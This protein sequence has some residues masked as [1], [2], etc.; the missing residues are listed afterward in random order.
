[1]I[2]KEKFICDMY[3]FL[4]SKGEHEL[5]EEFHEVFVAKCDREEYIELYQTR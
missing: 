5:I 1:M 3:D 4:E 2:S